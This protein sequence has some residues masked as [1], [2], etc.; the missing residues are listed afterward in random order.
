MRSYLLK[1][2]GEWK[3]A[4]IMGSRTSYPF[5]WLCFRRRNRKR[6]NKKRI[7]LKE[8]LLVLSENFPMYRSRN[9]SCNINRFPSQ[10]EHDELHKKLGSRNGKNYWNFTWIP[11]IKEVLKTASF[12]F[13]LHT[14]LIWEVKSFS[15][16]KNIKN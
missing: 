1:E 9:S 14:K 8:P 3:K 16:N 4:D 13:H 11:R 15:I 5:W 12:I 7:S 10:E 2:D 6:W